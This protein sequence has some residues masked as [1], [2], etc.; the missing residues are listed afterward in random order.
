MPITLGKQLM[1]T[2][3][4]VVALLLEPIEGFHV[5]RPPITPGRGACAR[6]W[7]QL[8]T[9]TDLVEPPPCPPAPPTSDA[10]TPLVLTLCCGIAAV[11]ALDRVVMSVAILPMSAQYGYPDSIKGLIAAGFSV[12]YGLAL[13]P[14]GAAASSPDISPKTVL[15]VGLLIW[16]AAQAASPLAASF[17][18]PVLLGA[19]ALMGIGEAAAIPS[20]QAIAAQFVPRRRRSLFWGFLSASLSGGTILAYLLSPPL[21]EDYGWSSAFVAFGGAGLVLAALWAAFGAAEPA[22]PLPPDHSGQGG[23]GG[24]AGLDA[25]TPNSA[26][27]IEEACPAPEG[28]I[29]LGGSGRVPWAAIAS[30]RPVWAL[31]AAHVASN[32]FL[33]FALTWLPVFFSYS[34]GMSTAD[35]SSASITPFAAGAVGALSAGAAC[36]AL[37]ARAGFS[38]TDARKLM[39][40]VA[41]GGPALAL[42]ALA[43]LG[44]GW[45]GLPPLDRASAEAIFTFAIF[46][47]ACSAAGFG[48]AAQDISTRL[49]ALL[50]GATSVAAV[51]AGAGGQYLTGWLLERNGRDFTPMFELTAAVELVGLLLWLRF[52]DSE[53]LFE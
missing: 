41:C 47:Q 11:C 23:A 29:M 2:S 38:L 14:A 17:G 6:H 1:Q 51:A 5:A 16:S 27:C 53:K 32:F 42:L 9:R 31:T 45:A 34:F 33:Y 25:G 18:V 46:C 36:D 48:C 52:W 22:A 12:G 35:S 21:I 19:R 20:L 44:S 39:Q 10:S 40:S 50:Y 49:S 7:P 15:L 13:L 28:A 37:V 3:L 30:S 8:T 26:G 43:A 4:V 24:G